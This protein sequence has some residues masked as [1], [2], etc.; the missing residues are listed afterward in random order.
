MRLVA[1]FDDLLKDLEEYQKSVVSGL[2]SM[3]RGFAYEISQ[4]A[5]NNTPLGNA[6]QYL[7]LYR[8]RYEATGLYPQEGFARGSWQATNKTEAQGIQANYGADSGATALLQAKT[9]LTNYKL[10]ETVYIT[11]TGPYINLLEGGLSA[12]APEGIIKPTLKDIMATYAVDLRTYYD[13]AAK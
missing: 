13:K 4:H 8:R 2:E 11:N 9:S 5:I 3:V 10:G 1:N 7:N 6:E 12:Q